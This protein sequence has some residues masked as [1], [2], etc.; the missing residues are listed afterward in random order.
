MET[1]KKIIADY[2]LEL[3]DFTPDEVKSVMEDII[4]E[5]NLRNNGILVE[6]GYSNKL[7]GIMRRKLDI[8]A[9]LSKMGKNIDTI[10][11]DEYQYIIQSYR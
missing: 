1:F 8:E 3:R 11:D 2:E 4:R 7:I 9:N 10:T 6:D 5:S